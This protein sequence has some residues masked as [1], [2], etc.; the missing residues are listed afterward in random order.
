LGKYFSGEDAKVVVTTKHDISF[1]SHELIWNDWTSIP[2]KNT[3][4]LAGIDVYMKNRQLFFSDSRTMKI[5]R[6]AVD[7]RNLTEACSISFY[8]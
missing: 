4:S 1:G 3:A 7:G 2:V 8:I 6:M 5:Y